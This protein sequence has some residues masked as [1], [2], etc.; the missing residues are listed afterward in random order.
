MRTLFTG[1]KVFDGT[2]GEV[3]TGDVL[4]ED[5]RIVEVGTGLDGDES[6]DVG[7][8]TLLP[9]LFDCHVHPLMSQLDL[10]RN[11]QTP[12]SYKYFKCAENLETTLRLGITTIRDAGGS[13]LGIKQAVQDGLINGPR[14]HISIVMLSQTGGHGDSWM[15]CGAHVS[16]RTVDPGRPNH[17]VDGPEE[18]RRK[19]RELVRMGAD[20][21][22]VAVSG[23]VL[24][25]R[26]KPTHAHFRPIELE[27]LVEEATAAGIFVMSHAQATDGIK[28][29]IRAG[30]RSIDHGIYLDDEAIDLM[31]KRGTW[32]VP[33]LLAPRGVIAAA[34]AGVA[35]TDA[36]VEK[37]H[38]VIDV[39]SESFRRA[40]EAGVKV[41]MGTD[42]P[43]SP[44]GTNLGELEL[45]T[46]LSD[47]TSLDALVA[48]TRSAAELMG[49]DDE[50]GTLE[51]GKRADV[52]VVDG[53]ALDFA[54]LS[55]RIDQVWKDGIRVV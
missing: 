55:D 11:F 30:I 24:S 6:V 4:I 38:E 2:G 16:P 39:H 9:G 8:K 31:L 51:T 5:G 29:A 13:D 42:C 54:T 47:M 23:G 3:A 27:V 52:V 1:G 19:V 49:L 41:A 50:L 32:L 35:L 53:D 28:N 18:M 22:K 46:K 36:A 43:V 33:T 17:I 21:I 10:M 34:E 12:F 15:P 7:G 44:H 25:P 20:V 37:A 40:V 45:M 14:M 48:T 26:D